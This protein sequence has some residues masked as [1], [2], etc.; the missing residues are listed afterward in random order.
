MSGYN[1]ISKLLNEARYNLSSAQ[2][3]RQKIIDL[4]Q[5]YAEEE[6]F[7]IRRA[8]LGK[9][10][11]AQSDLALKPNREYDYHRTYSDY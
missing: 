3:L 10:K 1:I 7:A 6:D 5:E 2:K 8:L 9:I 11:R 4:K